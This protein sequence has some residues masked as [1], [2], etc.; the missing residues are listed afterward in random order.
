MESC[1]RKDGEEAFWLETSIFV[2]RWQTYFVKKYSFEP[3]Y[4]F[5]L[6]FFTIPQAVA[7]KLEM[8]QR[9]FL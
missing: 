8:I 5:F 4:L 9:N 3:P 1:Y 6:S 2:K 7:A